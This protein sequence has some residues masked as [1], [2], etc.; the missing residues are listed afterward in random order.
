MSRRFLLTGLAV[1]LLCAF[2]LWL[3]QVGMEWDYQRKGR[4]ITDKEWSEMMTENHG[5][6]P[7]AFQTADRVDVD[8]IIRLAVGN[9][10]LPSAEERGRV[11]DLVVAE[12]RG[13]RG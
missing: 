5:F 8:Q 4:V 9:I 12:L 10:G 3:I 2:L 13:A 11:S 1:R 7:V 6:T